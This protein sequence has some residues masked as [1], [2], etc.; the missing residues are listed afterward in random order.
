MDGPMSHDDVAELLGAYALDALDADE[1]VLVA[2]HLATCPRCS[3]EVAEHQEVVGLI[4]NVGADA[5]AELWDR[6]A[7]RIA[8]PAPSGRAPAPLA[9]VTGR[10]GRRLGATRRRRAGWS[11]AG[12]VAAA[13]AAVIAVLSVQ[14]AHLNDRVAQ[15]DQASA[16]QGLAQ[17]VLRAI[18]NPTTH[19]VSL[20]AP[21][22]GRPV[23]ELFILPSGTGYVTNERLP[24]LASDRTYQLW[25]FVR[26]QP[27]SLGLL[28]SRPTYATFTVDP[29]VR[30]TTYA[31]TDEQGG[32]V[33]HPTSSPVALSSST[34]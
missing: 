25:G 7:A 21:S 3:A 8:R 10:A 9:L 2:D 30:V 28:S 19:T 22:G 17:S 24:A 1:S 16:H 27:V 23:L 14:V 26:G 33:P 20:T 31:V 4:S 29:S 15:L 12:A 5:P 11:A 34:A 18:A 32:G 13:A 6:I